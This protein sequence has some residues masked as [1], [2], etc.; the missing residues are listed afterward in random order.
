MSTTKKFLQPDRKIILIVIIG[1]IFI[2]SNF[3][4]GKNNSVKLGFV[5]GKFP[6]S[7]NGWVGQDFKFEEK[8]GIFEI[9]SPENFILRT[10]EKKNN[11]NKINTA[12]ILADNK[13]EIHDPRLCYN[14]Q[15]FKF[16]D[17]KIK[18][19]APNLNL[20]YIKTKKADKEYL[21]IYWYTDL[22]KNYA[23]RAEFWR[24]IIL[25]KIFGKPVK[26]YG[27]VILYTPA[28]NKENLENFA[29]ETNNILFG[30]K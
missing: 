28:K 10:Y 9:I 16:L 13:K 29:L 21:F 1:F 3:N 18:Q 2:I 23:T 15:G 6:K 14:L 4:S 19:L 26:A 8:S 20:S 27:I 22:E 25:K 7:I 24:E 5:P 12:L 17:T 11:A 30:S